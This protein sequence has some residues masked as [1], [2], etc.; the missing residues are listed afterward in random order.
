MNVLA[1]TAVVYLLVSTSMIAY[2]NSRSSEE[3][4]YSCVPSYAN[5]GNYEQRLTI[6][7]LLE[8]ELSLSDY[9]N[10]PSRENDECIG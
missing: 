3:R 4:S 8:L 7:K 2:N 1:D 5:L 9:L 10:L 6:K